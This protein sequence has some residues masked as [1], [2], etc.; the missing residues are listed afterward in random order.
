MERW[1]D[2]IMEQWDSI[3]LNISYAILNPLIHDSITRLLRFNQKQ[4][5]T[6]SFHAWGKDFNL[7]YFL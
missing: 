1:I 5:K 3:F 4:K 7:A 6:K 2:G